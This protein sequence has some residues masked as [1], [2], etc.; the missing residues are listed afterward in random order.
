[1]IPASIAADLT[2]FQQ[3]VAAARPISA[4]SP[5]Q[6]KVLVGQGRSLLAEVDAAIAAVG[7]ALDGADPSGHPLAMIAAINARAAAAR[8]ATLLVDLRGLLGRALLNLSAGY[9]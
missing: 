6:L 5:L 2:A 7:T 1:M 8:D 3:A 9:A 4:L